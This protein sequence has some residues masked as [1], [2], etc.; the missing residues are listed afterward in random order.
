M[1]T[2]KHNGV[3]S[4]SL[5]HELQ[6]VHK[7]CN[8][9]N[10][11]PDSCKSGDKGT[12][13]LSPFVCP[14]ISKGDKRTVPLSPKCRILTLLWGRVS[15]YV[16]VAGFSFVYDKNTMISFVHKTGGGLL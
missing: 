8:Q 5:Y 15:L 7:C 3:L 2:D 6:I 10:I 16:I 9:S 12:V 13:L 14:E 4:G 11:N 1:V